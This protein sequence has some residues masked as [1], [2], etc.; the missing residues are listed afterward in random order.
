[1]QEV[2][3]RFALRSQVAQLHQPKLQV[4]AA[5]E[6]FLKG[7]TLGGNKAHLKSLISGSVSRFLDDPAERATS[8]VLDETTLYKSSHIVWTV[9][10]P[11]LL[12]AAILL[13]GPVVSL[14][15]VASP[16]AK[17]ALVAM[18]TSVFAISVA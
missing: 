1:M 7:I 6:S 2:D 16:R 17:L 10:I 12:L 18:Y 14:Y 3:E 9:A 8:E 11:D 13:I 15:D 5:H 4:I